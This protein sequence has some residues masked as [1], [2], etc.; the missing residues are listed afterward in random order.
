MPSSFIRSTMEVRQF[1]FCPE[2]D[3]SWVRIASTSTCCTGAGAAAVAPAV[4]VEAAAPPGTLA[5]VP[6]AVPAAVP[7]GAVVPAVPGA[8]VPPVAAGLRLNMASRILLKM[9]IEKSPV[10]GLWGAG[11]LGKRQSRAG[12]WLQ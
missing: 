4:P 1:S 6:A 10:V 8:G 5:V 12:R 9:L 11:C 2:L 3:D 7:A